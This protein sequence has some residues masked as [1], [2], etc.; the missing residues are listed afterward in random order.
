MAEALTALGRKASSPPRSPILYGSAGTLISVATLG[1]GGIPQWAGVWLTSGSI[2]FL[3]KAPEPSGLSELSHL[4]DPARRLVDLVQEAARSY[5]ERL[6]EIDSRLNLLQAKH[7][8]VPLTEIATMQR[9]VAVVREHAGR[10]LAL[11]TLLDGPFGQRFPELPKALPAVVHGLEGIQNLSG[12]TQQALRDLILLR[13]AEDANRIA[14]AA[15]QLSATSNRIAALA[16]TSNIRMLGLAYL[17]LVLGLVSAVVLI[18]NTAA[19]ILGMPSAAWVPGLWVTIVVVITAAIPLV[20]VF[21]RPWVL[22]MLR[23]MKSYE[24][25]SEEGLGDLPEIPPEPQRA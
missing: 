24:F 8:S 20:L 12:N 23:G 6:E 1:P 22:Q 3:G 9:Q 25:R 16:N 17:A 21:S 14:E 18:P 11:A 15:N 13:N 5:L 2:Q 10:A 7:S 19:T 4:P